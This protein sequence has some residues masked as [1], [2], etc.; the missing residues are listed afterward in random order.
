VPLDIPEL[1]LIQ[2]QMGSTL[3]RSPTICPRSTD[4]HRLLTVGYFLPLD[5]ALPNVPGGTL[6]WPNLRRFSPSVDGRLPPLEPVA[7]GACTPIQSGCS[8]TVI[9]SEY[10]R[11]SLRGLF[12]G[13]SMPADRFRAAAFTTCASMQN[14]AT[15]WGAQ[16]EG[17]FENLTEKM[18]HEGHEETGAR[19]FVFLRVPSWFK[20]LT[21]PS[22]L[23]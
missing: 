23:R 8:L 12:A 19:F 15:L 11:T 9:W 13:G 20:Y 1:G 3:P 4:I 7:I 6:V 22:Q 18:N 16:F 2:L 5:L 17:F 21:A 10:I 14:C